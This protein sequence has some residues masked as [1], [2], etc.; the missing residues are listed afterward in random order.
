MSKIS[1]ARNKRTEAR[2]TYVRT[3]KEA[4]KQE[5]KIVGEMLDILR[6]ADKPMTAAQ[7]K[8]ACKG[9]MSSYEIAGDLCAMKKHES[10]YI[11]GEYSIATKVPSRSNTFPE[12]IIIKRGKFRKAQMAEIDENGNV[13]PNTVRYVNIKEHNRY[14]IEKLDN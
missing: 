7:I 12:Q 14:S 9:N 6:A 1:E 2:K 8:C 11:Y 10:R 5:G 4:Q 13:I 3:V